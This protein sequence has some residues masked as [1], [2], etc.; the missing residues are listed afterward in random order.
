M[1]TLSVGWP[2]ASSQAAK[3][4][5]RIYFRDTALIGSAFT[6]AGCLMFALFVQEGTGLWRVALS[7]FLVGVGLWFASVAIPVVVQSVVGWNR[8]GVVTGANMFMRS[9]GSAVGVA[10]FGSIAN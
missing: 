1:A 5:L 2:V 4:Y 3:L 10:V 6:I 9:L 8:R 7:S